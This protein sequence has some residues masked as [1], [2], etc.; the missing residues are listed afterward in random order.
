MERKWADVEKAIGW[1]RDNAYD[2]DVNAKQLWITKSVFK[3]QDCLIFLDNGNGMDYEKMHKMFS[4]G[5]SDKQQLKKH[6]PVGLYGNGFKS[7]SMRLGKD[8]IVF[9]KKANTMCVGLLS[10]TYLERTGAQDVL[11]PIVSFTYTGQTDI[12]YLVTE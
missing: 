11:V 1:T 5:F 9:S 7:G 12:L 2:P 4:F 10:Q 3:H 6:V 8:A